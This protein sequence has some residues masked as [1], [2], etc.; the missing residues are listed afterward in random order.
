MFTIE[1]Q[2]G[3]WKFDSGMPGKIITL[4][5]GM[6]GGDR[7]KITTIMSL[8][9]EYTVI[10]GKIYF[11]IAH[12]NLLKNHQKGKEKSMNETFIDIPR[13]STDED[14]RAQD[15]LPFLRE[16]DILLS[17]D[18]EEKE[19][20]MY[21]Q[22]IEWAQFFDIQYIFM[23]MDTLKPRRSE[24]Y[25]H[26]IGKIGIYMGIGRKDT[27]NEYLKTQLT[28]FFIATETISGSVLTYKE[29]KIYRLHTI[30][31]APSTQ[32][33]FLK[34]WSEINPVLSG[35]GIAYHENI[36]IRAPYDGIMVFPKLPQ[37]VGDEM[38]IFGKKVS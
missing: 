24:S 7:T 17:I 33:W 9:D 18:Y 26:Q 28:N 3:I 11:I 19:S 30:L 29:Q 27:D 21:T 8:M 31:R 34:K 25:M 2:P 5:V 37:K 4:L 12:P 16:S 10:G 23:G 35:E 22:N 32:F 38:C 1:I 20:F 14:I 15:I 6:E 36:V 13:N